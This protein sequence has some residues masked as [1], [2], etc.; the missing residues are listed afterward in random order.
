MGQTTCWNER[1][2]DKS[3]IISFFGIK[4]KIKDDVSNGKISEIHERP[5]AD[6]Y[7]HFTVTNGRQSD[8][9]V[10]NFLDI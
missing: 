9:E 7:N 6:F 3:G 2:S 8:D 10:T 1:L 5:S 4:P